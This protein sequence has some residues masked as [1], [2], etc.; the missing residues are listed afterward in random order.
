MDLFSLPGN[1][2]SAPQYGG[3]SAACIDIHGDGVY[4]IIYTTF[5]P[6]SIIQCIHKFMQLTLT[7]ELEAF[8]MHSHSS[9]VLQNFISF[10]PQIL[11]CISFYFSTSNHGRFL[12]PD[13]KGIYKL[14]SITS[15]S[16]IV[17]QTLVDF[18]KQ[19][20]V[21]NRGTRRYLRKKCLTA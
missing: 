1:T 13:G 21:F 14:L 16:K 17:T 9:L 3:N 6:G 4:S 2:D 10:L 7:H 20:V 15:T 11:Q 18:G 19:D 8:D 12:F 5:T